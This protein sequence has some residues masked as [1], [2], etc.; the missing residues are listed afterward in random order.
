MRAT[1]FGTYCRSIVCIGCTLIF[2]IPGRGGGIIAG[3]YSRQHKKAARKLVEN[4][5]AAIAAG[6]CHRAADVKPMIIKGKKALTKLVGEAGAERMLTERPQKI[7]D[8][9]PPEK[10]WP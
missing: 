8:G 3:A 4:G 6:D 9:A 7:L 10:V 5:Q 2:R 1:L